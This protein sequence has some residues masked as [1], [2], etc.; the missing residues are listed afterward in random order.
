VGG[1]LGHGPGFHGRGYG[2]GYRVLDGYALLDG[3]LQLL[4]VVAG[5]IG[6]HGLQVKHVLPKRIGP[7]VFGGLR[8]QR[9]AVVYK[10]K[11]VK[12]KY[13]HDDS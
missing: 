3:R 8:W 6:P 12:A 1:T 7:A 2:V 4:E 13:C 11:R 10:F 9:L 5:H